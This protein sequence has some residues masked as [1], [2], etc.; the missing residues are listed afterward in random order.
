M[1]RISNPIQIKAPVSAAKEDSMSI[2]HGL[3]REEL[4][5]M[6]SI[7]ASANHETRTKP[8]F[9]INLWQG[10]KSFLGLGIEE[11]KKITKQNDNSDFRPSITI[12]DK[13]IT[14]D[15]IEQNS[16]QYVFVLSGN[17][18]KT[19]SRYGQSAVLARV[20][21]TVP[22]SV[23]ELPVQIE[24]AAILDDNHLT[25]AAFKETTEEELQK[26]VE[27]TSKA[28]DQAIEKARTTGKSIMLLKGGYGTGA[29]RMYFY[30]PK[31]FAAMNKLFE[32]KLGVKMWYNSKS[33]RYQLS[34][35]DEI[36]G[37][38]KPNLEPREKELD[39]DKITGR[40]WRN[41]WSVTPQ[42]SAA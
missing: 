12:Y 27:I 36:E 42:H 1:V 32:E 29:A 4:R 5:P 6:H 40:L 30:S 2:E 34:F 22:E 35:V 3:T 25:K 18:E 14:K 9:I 24:H 8:S 37:L 26:N 21:K 31:T 11:S 13:I 23:V 38:M 41:I 19:A 17:E 7:Q 15:F 39:E 33:S 20:K 10:L 16:D 28:L